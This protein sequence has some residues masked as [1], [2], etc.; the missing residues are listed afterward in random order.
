[1]SDLIKIVP[2][3]VQ[4]MKVIISIATIMIMVAKNAA[5]DDDRH[6]LQLWSKGWVL[7]ISLKDHVIFVPPGT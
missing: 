2:F 5:D 3:Y 7:K 4:S 1:M 6:N